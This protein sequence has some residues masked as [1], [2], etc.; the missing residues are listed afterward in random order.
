[1]R[2]RPC[3][4]TALKKTLLWIWDI[5]SPNLYQVSISTD[6]DDLYDRVGFRQ[7]SVEN[8][9][10]LLN[11]REVEIRG[12]NRHEEHP[13]FGFAFPPSLMK[14]DIDLAVQMCDMRTCVEA[15]LNRARGFNNKGLL[16]E[17]RKPKLA[18]REAKRLYNKFA[19]N[20]K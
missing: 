20:E 10:I 5:D 6:T 1:M 2:F 7:I 4:Y 12:V 8:E 14:R 19:D 15:G 16:N 17:Y 11:G 13:E 9:R 3:A 18:Y